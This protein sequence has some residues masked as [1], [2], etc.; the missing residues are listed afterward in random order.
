M[1]INYRKTR[2][3]KVAATI[4]QCPDS[5]R[6]EVVLSGKSNVGKSSLINA[7]ADNR[8]LAR[9][10]AS[11]GKTREVIYFETDDK[12]LFA[13]LPGYGYA[14]ASKEVKERF[15]R[16]CDDYFRSG[17]KIS[18]VLHLIDIRHEP[19]DR[20]KA[21]IEFLNQAQIPYFVVFTKCDKL[22]K[23]QCSKQIAQMSRYLDFSEDA[24]VFAVS[25]EKKQGIREL[26]DAITEFVF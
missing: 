15:S 8:K 7:I 1:E 12:L 16:L 20:D 11:P 23:M 4:A 5:D 18:L 21:M 13:D 9:V 10:S 26:C 14:K 19:S 6:P 3:L 25:S 17:R 2:F 22:S 24:F